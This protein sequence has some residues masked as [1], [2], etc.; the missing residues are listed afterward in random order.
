[1]SAGR[2]N[3]SWIRMEKLKLDKKTLKNFGITMA[4]AFSVVTLIIFF[5]QKYIAFPTATTSAIF[6]T[7][8]FISPTVLK[9]IYIFWMRLAFVLGWINTRLILIVLFYLIITPIGFCIRLFKGDL[10]DRKIEKNRGSYWREKE[11]TL[12]KLS[13]Y[14]SQF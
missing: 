14:E 5:R 13:N 9:P 7:L 11:K 12:F 8:A 3:L 6:L 2:K 4:I 1:M 10:L